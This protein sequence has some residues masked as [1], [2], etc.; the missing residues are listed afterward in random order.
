[1]VQNRKFIGVKKRCEI[2]SKRCEI[3]VVE[4]F[5]NENTFIYFICSLCKKIKFTLSARASNLEAGEH[6]HLGFNHLLQT[7]VFR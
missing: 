5:S 2:A 6:L 7:A 4:D 1:M 3:V